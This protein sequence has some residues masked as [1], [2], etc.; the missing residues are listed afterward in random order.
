VVHH[1]QRRDGHDRR[2][3]RAGRNHRSARCR[4]V[5]A[6]LDANG[7][8]DLAVTN[9]GDGSIDGTVRILINNGAGSFGA[10]PAY[11]VGRD[12]RS[13]AAAD[14][15]E[16]GAP[17]IDLVVANAGDDTVQVLNNNGDGTFLP[18]PPMLVGSNP[19][20]VD[21][22]DLDNDKDDDLAVTNYSTAE[23][24]AGG[25]PPG[26][27]VSVVLNYDGTFA[28]AVNLP[29]GSLP[30]AIASFDLE[31]DDDVDLAVVVTDELGERVVRILRNDLIHD[32]VV[33]D[34]PTFVVDQ[35]LAQGQDP[36]LVLAAD[37]DN[38][39]RDDLVAINGTGGAA[40]GA[41]NEVRSLLNF[42]T[43]CHWSCGD[44]DGQVGIVDFLALL[45]QWGVTGTS[46]DFNGGGVGI[47]DF[48]DL[49][50]HWGPCP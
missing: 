18:N 26:G 47:V 37:V 6:R 32:G 27:T 12:P 28:P 25:L 22:S 35:D 48:L 41:P 1:R 38:D 36:V 43:T 31:G 17:D 2:R 30:Q 39:G 40:A 15:G 29:V 42:S 49:L 46:C 19:L 13:I 34:Q 5:A 16:P 8:F 10:G 11:T 44:D 20:V 45:S 4:P 33:E 9:A 7:S 21:P 14:L 24:S 23:V 50:A 3:H